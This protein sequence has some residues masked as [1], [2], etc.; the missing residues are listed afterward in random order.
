[1]PTTVL[2]ISLLLMLT[3]FVG[4]ILPFLPDIILIFLGALI[5]GIYTGFSTV[6]GTVIIIFAG[7][8]ILSILIDLIASVIGAKAQ[9]A[10]IYGQIGAAVG[11]VFGLFFSGMLGIVL[12]P[13]LGVIAFE[14]IFAKRSFDKALSAGLGALVGFILS[15]V[16][17]IALAGFMIAWFVKL[18]LL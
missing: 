13:V 16:F 5:Y 17:K 3:G 15:S 2:I 8:T 9:K 14:M 12:G 6:S 11:A 18:V 7:L 1:M 10:T 4:I